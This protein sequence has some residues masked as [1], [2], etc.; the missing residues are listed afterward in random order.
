MFY[1]LIRQCLFQLESEKAHQFTLKS[2]Q[3]A[4]RLG[5][6]RLLPKMLSNP[7]E[8]FG[9]KFPNPIGLSA[10]FDRNADYIDALAMLGFGFIEIGTVMPKPQ[11][12]NPPPRIFRLTDQKALI[13]RMGFASQGL[14]YLIRNLEKTKYRGV[15][16]INIGKHKDTANENALDD[17]LLLFRELWKFASY[18]TINVSS[19]NTPGLRNLQS[20]DSLTHLL[21]NLKQEQK[22]IAQASKKYVPL[23][24]KISPDLKEQEL[25]E[26][27]EVLLQQ[28][29]DGVIACNTTISRAGVESSSYAKEAGGLSGKPLQTRNLSIIKQLHS[30][31]QN[32]IPII[33]SGGIMDEESARNA[34]GAGASLLEIYTGLI[35]E[36]PGLIRRL[37][38]L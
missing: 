34:F 38:K 36:G 3:I 33:A 4:Y 28:K 35:Y 25:F 37:A 7:R 23:V 8:V 21:T 12:G 18:I 9:L 5:L 16:G 24:V 2:L 19:P 15:L 6:L 30:I 17:Y 13:N 20:P 29:I 14:E 31:L 10:G 11:A 32:Q 27:A 1:P 22:K 26:L